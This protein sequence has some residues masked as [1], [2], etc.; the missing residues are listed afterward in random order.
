MFKFVIWIDAWEPNNWISTE[1]HG[2]SRHI[3]WPQAGRYIKNDKP[4]RKFQSSDTSTW[5]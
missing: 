3:I 4:V 5:L 2:K 1:F